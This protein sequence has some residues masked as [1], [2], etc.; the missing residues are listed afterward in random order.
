MKPRVQ[1]TYMRY[2]SYTIIFSLTVSTASAPAFAQR[3][4]ANANDAP[5]TIS[6][7]GPSG[8]SSLQQAARDRRTISL[9]NEVGRVDVPEFHDVS[10][11]DTLWDITNYYWGSPWQWPSLWGLNP[12]ITNP[13]WIFPGD[14]VRLLREG[15]RPRVAQPTNGLRTL[16]RTVTPDTVFHLTQGYLDPREEEVAGT[17]VG[18]PD[19]HLLLTAGNEVYVEFTRGTPN[20]GD[21]FTIYQDAQEGRGDRNTGRVVRLL[22][23]LDVTRWDERRHIATAR[24]VEA[25][26]TIER[27]ER[28][29]IIP[30]SVRTVPPVASTLDLE[31]HIAATVR[32]QAIVGQNQIVF[33]DR[34][35]DD[36]VVVGNRFLVVRQGDAWRRTLGSISESH[37]GQSGIDR[38]GDGHADP[39]PGAGQN[40][41]DRMPDVVVGEAL[42]VE[43][44]RQTSTAILTSS[45]VELTVGDRVLLRRGY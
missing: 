45:T 11:G 8:P 37:A 9:S 2:I 26:D 32:P 15:T 30:R 7:T 22:G 23:T 27:G 14:R 38:D 39:P 42:V 43:T 33:I 36:H 5:V 13:H 10:R 20:V 35:A 18:S 40:P 25:L 41:S 16:A 34:G 12:Q 21:E 31:G 19:D 29:G 17:L 3:I 4:D 1:T 6:N 24:I 28:V 44:R